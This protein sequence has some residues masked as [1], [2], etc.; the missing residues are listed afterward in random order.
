ME[1]AKQRRA[2]DPL[3]HLGMDTATDGDI[4]TIG[5]G[6][7]QR[8]IILFSVEIG[9]ASV[10]EK[11]FFPASGQGGQFCQANGTGKP[12]MCISSVSTPSS[13]SAE[14]SS[15]RR[16]AVLPSF[17]GLPLIAITFMMLSLF[18]CVEEGMGGRGNKWFL[19]DL[20]DG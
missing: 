14:R 8:D 10:Q 1:P 11:I 19:K 6:E 16:A 2:T 9:L 17:R 4:L 12:P 15:S 18:G 20:T 7:A 13:F 5:A 3:D